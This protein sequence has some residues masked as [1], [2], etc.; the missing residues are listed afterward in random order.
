MPYEDRRNKGEILMTTEKLLP[1]LNVVVYFRRK[2][3]EE[4][5]SRTFARAGIAEKFVQRQRDRW[6]FFNVH[7]SK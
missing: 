1:R 2:D 4:V 6:D 5:E 7:G 3:K